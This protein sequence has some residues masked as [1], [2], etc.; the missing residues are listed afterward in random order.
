[1]VTGVAEREGSKPAIR[2]WVQ[3]QGLKR[4][5]EPGP[6]AERYQV[7][8]LQ[9]SASVMAAIVLAL[10]ILAISW[11]LNIIDLPYC[12]SRVRATINTFFQTLAADGDV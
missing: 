11:E 6:R 10:A 5:A 12:Y 9:K 1:M 2:Y 3:D 7:H 8:A 4:R